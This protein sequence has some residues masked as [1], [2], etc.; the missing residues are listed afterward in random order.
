MAVRHLAG[1]GHKR[2]GFIIGDR[3]VA[4]ARDR[5][6]GIRCAVMDHTKM[7]LPT[8]MMLTRRVKP[9]L[10]P[11]GYEAALE[12]L[13]SVP[14]PTALFCAAGDLVAEGAYQAAAKLGLRVPED[15]SILGY[16]D[17]PVAQTLQ[18]ALSTLHQPL[19]QMGAQ[20]AARLVQAAA[21]TAPA[22]QQSVKP[23]L[24]QRQS[25]AAPTP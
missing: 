1:L 23:G 24:M 19:E 12:L 21:G 2:I 8:T 16:D 5:E 17:L 9:A 20:L 18:P 14:R 11:Q 15:L 6:A 13:R 10:A 3:T 25:C 22:E 4:E 7:D